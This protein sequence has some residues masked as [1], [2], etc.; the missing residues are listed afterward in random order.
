MS[1]DEAVRKTADTHMML[2]SS[3]WTVYL[4]AYILRISDGAV[5]AEASILPVALSAVG[6]L[7]M[8]AGAG[9]RFGSTKQ[10]ARYRGLSLVDRACQLAEAVC[11]GPVVLVTG[12]DH[13]AVIRDTQLAAGFIVHNERHAEGLATSN[14][15]AVQ[16]VADVAGSVLVLLAD[17]P[18]ITRH[19]LRRLLRRAAA[20]PDC[21]I[22]SEFA[23]TQGPPALFPQ[24]YFAELAQ[25]QGDRGARSL[26]QRHRDRVI[27]L[28]CDDAATDVDRPDDL[29]ALP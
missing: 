12:A 7:V 21:I 8:A 3:A 10:L 17:Q 24:H 5:A 15:V 14:A 16:A 4:M 22:A 28:Q 9:R 2:M 29:T 23:G 11:A 18:L 1:D 27:T 6:F 20:A 25:L 19:Y 13:L 26:L